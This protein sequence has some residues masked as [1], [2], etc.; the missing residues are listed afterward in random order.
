VTWAVGTVL[1]A[2]AAVSSIGAVVGD[3]L[4]IGSNGTAAT[5]TNSSPLAPV[6]GYPLDKLFRTTNPA[7]SPAGSADPRIEASH[8]AVDAALSGGLA[9]ADR[10][11]LTDLVAART[12]VSQADAQRRV[13]DFMTSV[14][15][16]QSK[17]KAAADAARRAAAQLSIYTALSM[18]VGAFIASVA[19]AIGGRQ[20]DLHL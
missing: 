12:G 13:D 1:I 7:A 14:L 10:S 19:A 2:V 18:L 3:N 8:I 11:Y 5:T 20:R 16:A 15:Q 9:D 4:H 6:A 17:V